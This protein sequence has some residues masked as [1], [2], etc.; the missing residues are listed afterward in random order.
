MRV[1]KQVKIKR[2]E[3]RVRML[4]VVSQVWTKTANRLVNAEVEAFDIA[5]GAAIKAINERFAL[6]T[7]ISK[8]RIPKLKGR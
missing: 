7:K 6:A 5:Y 3:A 1:N 4:R 2:L 8:L